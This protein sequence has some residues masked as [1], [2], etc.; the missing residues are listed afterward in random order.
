VPPNYVMMWGML[1]VMALGA[2]AGPLFHGNMIGEVRAAYP[3]DAAKRDA[4]DRCGAM[5]ADFSRFSAPDR[6]TCYRALLHD[7]GAAAATVAQD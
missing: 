7:T 6:D 4:L 5:D 3:A 2:L 1:V